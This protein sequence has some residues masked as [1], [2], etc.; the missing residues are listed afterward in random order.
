M[1]NG[2]A[3]D[4]WIARGKNVSLRECIVGMGFSVLGQHGT[5]VGSVFVKALDIGAT[6]AHP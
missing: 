6:Q 3:Y 5:G 4:V 2:D 1:G